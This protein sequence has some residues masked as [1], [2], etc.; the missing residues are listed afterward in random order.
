MPPTWVLLSLLSA[1][2]L[3]TSDALTKRVITHENEYIIGWFR[4]LFGIPAL[5]A[6]LMLSGPLPLIDGPFLWSFAAALPLE[7][8]A[9]LLY[10]KALRLS[11]L[12]LSLPFLSFTPVFLILLSFV[13]VG[14]RVSPLGALGIALIGLGGYTLN[15]SALRSGFLEPFRAVARERGSL[16]MLIIA[17]IYSVTSALG[18]IGV[19]HSSPA[20]FGFTYFLALAVCMLPILVRQCG[21]ERLVPLLKSTTR[22]ALLPAL[23][24]VMAT[25]AHFYAVSMANVAY[26]IAV[27]RSSL[28]I[29]TIYG[30][31]LFRE[32]NIRERL[33]GAALMFAGFVV[34]VIGG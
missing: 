6:A 16:Y 22:I 19:D 30:F 15:L 10:Y 31:V 33:V 4:I 12:S 14:Q 27:K 3:A 8:A 9:I 18:K 29:G 2:C 32:M 13:L 28:L 5:F 17:L 34:V 1:F 7:I 20:F 21:R 24:D 23:F 25:V 26:M 11:P